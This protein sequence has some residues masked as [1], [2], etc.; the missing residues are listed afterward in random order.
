MKRLLKKIFV[1]IIDE[2]LKPIRLKLEHQEDVIR[3][4]VV[5]DFRNRARLNRIQ[6]RPIHIVFVCHMT[7]LWNMF[8]S[9]YE[10]VSYDSTFI[11]TVVSLP[12]RHDSLQNG[13]YKDDG[14]FEYLQTKS[15][16]VVKGYDKENNKWLNPLDLAP[17]YVFFQTPYNN[18]PDEWSTVNLSLLSKICYVPYGG[19][20]YAGEVDEIVNPEDFFSKVSI[21]FKENEYSKDKFIKRFSQKKWF[22]GIST[23]I[24][25]CPK[26][27]FLTESESYTGIS[28]RRGLHEGVKRILWTPRWRTTEGNCHFF[29]YKQFFI[30]YCN[31]HRNI[32]FIFRPHPLSLQNFL[33]TGELSPSDLENMESAYRN[34]SNM[35]IETNSGYEDSFVTS[36]F[37]VSDMSTILFEY[38]AT[39]KPVIYTHR[40][41]HFNE[42][43]KQMS[44]GFYWVKNSTELHDVLEMLLS[45]QDPLKSRREEIRQ[46]LMYIPAGGA[47]L[48]IKDA[49]RNDY[50]NL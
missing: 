22:S 15:I 46:S 29:D 21:V 17:D 33:K 31:D 49:I 37:L 50:I 44:E 25:G 47:G 6:N 11:A 34:S 4:L 18:F 28:W 26:L 23:Y 45:G 36:D 27:D 14:V 32:D 8:D 30:D 3:H 39:G 12:Y 35:S 38:F 9:I 19:C 48:L 40:V 43:G 7:A 10:A 24:S 41:D 1:K 2:S 5:A 16:N 42:F 20:I 13:E